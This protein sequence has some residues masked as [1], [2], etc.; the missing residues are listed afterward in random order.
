MSSRRTYALPALV[1]TL[2]LLASGC[3]S[4]DSTA[5]ASTTTAPAASASPAAAAT[6]VS[7]TDPW[8]KAADK[9][10]T[11]AFGTLVNNTDK[12]LTIVSATSDVSMMELHEMV[13]KDGKMIMQP[14]EGGFT[15]PAK[16]THELSP[17]GDHIMFMDVKT[18]VKAGDE[19]AV[20]LKLADGT[21]VPFTA[22]GKPFSGAEESY[23]P[24]GG[25]DMSMSESPAA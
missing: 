22:I 18:P 17:G 15:L 19:V 13:M 11:A 8:I 10:M 24:E 20:T 12:P 2:G 23:A 5:T 25:M 21:T 14:K 3:S 1:L 4:D 9:G 6:A 7:I 16:G